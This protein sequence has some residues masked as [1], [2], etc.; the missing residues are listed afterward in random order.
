MRASVAFALALVAL[1]G[2]TDASITKATASEG[3]FSHFEYFDGTEVIINVD[4]GMLLSTH[5]KAWMKLC[6]LVYLC[7]PYV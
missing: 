6:A 1:V 2:L 4:G 3:V 7:V 5:P